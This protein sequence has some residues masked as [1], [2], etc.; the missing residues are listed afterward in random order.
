MR[1]VQGW[2]TGSY[3]VKAIGIM[4][5]WYL[6]LVLFHPAW[7]LQKRRWIL[8]FPNPSLVVLL[9]PL[10]LRPSPNPHF[11]K[12]RI[13]GMVHLDQVQVHQWYSAIV[14]A[15][16]VSSFHLTPVCMMLMLGGS[17]WSSKHY[18][19]VCLIMVNFE[20]TVTP[21]LL[22]C[23]PCTF[24]NMHFSTCQAQKEVTVGAFG[25]HRH[26]VR[27]R[28]GRHCLHILFAVQEHTGI[29]I[30][31]RAFESEIQIICHNQLS[32]YLIFQWASG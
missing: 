5:W 21:Y 28:N 6:S 29:W 20:K 26:L 31:R 1:A 32:I 12:T 16:L 19:M 10:A 2:G 7:L 17:S 15:I 24:W 13:P 22:R 23:L 18:F 14:T 4:T 8:G 11:E 25:V 27:N 9:T 30:N 3:H